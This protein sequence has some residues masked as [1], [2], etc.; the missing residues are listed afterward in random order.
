MDLR[1]NGYGRCTAQL[2]KYEDTE[3]TP[4]QVRELQERQDKIVEQ[5]EECE[6]IQF[7]SFSKS[8][9]TV[10]DAIEIVKGGGDD[11]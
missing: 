9:I 1:R 4:E 2:A 7:A 3:L 6:N 11:A 5:L 8:M 10:E